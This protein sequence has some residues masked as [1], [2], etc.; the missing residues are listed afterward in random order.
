MNL[1][2]LTLVIV[3][4]IATIQLERYATVGSIPALV[5]T[6]LPLSLAAHTA[7][8]MRWTAIWATLDGAVLAI[9]AGHTQASAILALA[10]LVAA[11]VAE[12]GV[13]VFATPIGIASAGIANAAPMLSAIQI[14]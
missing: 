10:M 7:L 11:R 13:A 2:S 4:A 6:T 12:F 1:S 3:L 8:T 9:P 5:T 14:A